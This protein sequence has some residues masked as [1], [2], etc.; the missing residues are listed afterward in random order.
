MW[1]VLAFRA[2]EADA[3]VAVDLAALNAVVDALARC[4]RMGDAEDQLE[5]A[6]ELC[7]RRGAVLAPALCA[8]PLTAPQVLGCSC[9]EG[10]FR[11]NMDH[12]IQGRHGDPPFTGL[13]CILQPWMS[14]ILSSSWL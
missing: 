2:M 10:P 7:R 8:T 1:Q 6:T 14:P 11:A 13:Q 5:R 4:G 3:R 9:M 12:I